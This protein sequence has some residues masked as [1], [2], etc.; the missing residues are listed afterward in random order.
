MLPGGVRIAVLR[1]VAETRRL[2]QRNSFW[3]ALEQIA[4]KAQYVTYSHRERA[5][6]FKA[7]LTVG[8]RESIQQVL[9]LLKNQALA[10]RIHLAPFDAIEFIVTR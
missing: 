1:E 8:Q 7:A 5:D 6:I 4:G 9:Q 10:R 3:T 2:F